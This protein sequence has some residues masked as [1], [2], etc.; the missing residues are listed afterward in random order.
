MSNDIDYR[1]VDIPTDEAPED[2]SYAERRAEILTLIEQAGHPSLLSSSQLA[3]RYGCSQ[4][5]I[6]NDI[7][8]VLA[9]YID[10]T[11]G[12]RRI[13]TTHAVIEKSVKSLLENEEYRKASQTI[14]DFNRWVD[15]HRDQQEF[16][17]RL[18]D[19]E[20]RLAEGDSVP[21]LDGL[22]V[23]SDGGV[24]LRKNR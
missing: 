12:D 14:L 2:F 10:K 20:N 18:A 9:S 11:L 19:I 13:L 5:T 23:E 16:E 17:E 21:E 7:N 8:N 4:P 1:N 15:D 3:D 22:T 6:S 24:D